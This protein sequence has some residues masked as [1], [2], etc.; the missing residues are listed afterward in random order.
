MCVACAV[1]PLYA[2]GVER[3][4][5]TCLCTVFGMSLPSDAPIVRECACVDVHLVPE[6]LQCFAWAA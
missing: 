4:P 3:V 1:Y 2:S 6:R 5:R